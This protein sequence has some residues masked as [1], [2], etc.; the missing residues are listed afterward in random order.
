MRILEDELRP[1]QKNTLPPDIIANDRHVDDVLW[2]GPR[3]GSRIQKAGGI[4]IGGTLFLLGLL[5]V[6]IFYGLGARLLLAPIFLLTAFG[7]RILFKALCG[8]NKERTI[9]K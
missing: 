1:G 3:P 9:G 2:N 5:N 4:V 6:S 7:A 8:R